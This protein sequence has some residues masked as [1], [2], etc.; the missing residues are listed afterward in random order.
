MGLKARELEQDRAFMDRARS[1]K[2][3]RLR[4]IF[5]KVGAVVESQ[6]K[7]VQALLQLLQATTEVSEPMLR[8]A[9]FQIGHTALSDCQEEFFLETDESHPTKL[10]RVLSGLCASVRGPSSAE[11][12]AQGCSARVLLQETLR[13]H[14]LRACPLLVPRSAAE[15]L[16]GEAFLRDMGF[17]QNKHKP[18]VW[19]DRDKW[20]ARMSKLLCTCAV[21]MIQP[22]QTP[23]AVSDAW[24]WTC[25]MLNSCALHAAAGTSPPFYTATALEVILRVAAPQLMRA[26]GTAFLKILGCLR[27]K[28]LSSFSAEMPKRESLKEFLDRFLS[29][30]GTDHMS[31][32]IKK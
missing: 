25:R 22:E 8:Y 16:E 13:A 5:N 31:L 32:F 26:Y 21:L 2:V 15:G 1:L 4:G 3:D 24:T 7:A 28:V 9:I 19:E 29:S 14:F 11:E 12:E 10:A 17:R 18:G 6:T 27:E 23:F 30:K 20:L